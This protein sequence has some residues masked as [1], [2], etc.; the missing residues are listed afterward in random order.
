[1]MIVAALLCAFVALSAPVSGMQP[2]NVSTPFLF[3]GF[4]STGNLT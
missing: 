2:F 4:D 1:M 3:Y